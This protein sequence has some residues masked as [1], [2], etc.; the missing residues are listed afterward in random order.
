MNTIIFEAPGISCHHCEQ[1]ITGAVGTLAGVIETKVD[2][3]AKTVTVDYD[4]ER[5]SVDTITQAI[6]SQ[7]YEV[8]TRR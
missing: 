1:A 8:T 3:P 7:G 6:E 2:V 5:V 4:A